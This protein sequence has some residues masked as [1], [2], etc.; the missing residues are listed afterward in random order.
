MYEV[1]VKTSFSAAHHLKGYEGSCAEMHGHNW[2]AEVFVEGEKLDPA[3][4]LIDFRV[5]KDKVRDVLSRL[6]HKDLNKTEE[7]REVNPTSESIAKFIYDMVSTAL[8]VRDC[9][10]SKVVVRE[11][12]DTSA[13]YM[14]TDG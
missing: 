7:F 3:G 6:D 5:L 13:V 4:M 14:G 9:R 10:V 11:T 8:P 12:R 1:S 2:E